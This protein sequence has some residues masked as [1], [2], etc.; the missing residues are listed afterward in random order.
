MSRDVQIPIFLLVIVFVSAVNA[1]LR[2][3]PEK[4]IFF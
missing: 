4:P 1:G 3:L 2:V